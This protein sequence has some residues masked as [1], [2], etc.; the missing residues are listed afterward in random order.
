MRRREFIALVGGVAAWPLA[1]R[2]QQPERKRRI[3]V[4]IQ[5]AESDQEGQ[6]RL[7]AFR[8]KLFK[9]TIAGVHPMTSGLASLWQNY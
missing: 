4:M 5:L 8:E 7:A 1:S 2:A 3:G 9:S 6:S